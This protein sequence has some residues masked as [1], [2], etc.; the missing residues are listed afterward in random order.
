[1]SFGRWLLFHAENLKTEMERFAVSRHQTQVAQDFDAFDLHCAALDKPPDMED[2]VGTAVDTLLTE[3]ERWF[4]DAELDIKN[5]VNSHPFYVMFEPSLG[6]DART[7]HVSPKSVYPIFVADFSDVMS[8]LQCKIT[9]IIEPTIRQL[10][11]SREAL[12]FDSFTTQMAGTSGQDIEILALQRELDALKVT[13]KDL[14]LQ[15]DEIRDSLTKEINMLREQLFQKKVRIG[16]LYKPDFAPGSGMDATAV[17][18]PG[19]A[20]GGFTQADIDHAVKDVTDRFNE[21]KKRIDGKHRAELQSAETQ[22]ARLAT[23]IDALKSRLEQAEA[24]AD[25]LRTRCEEDVD[26][27]KAY[28]D[29][30]IEY[31]NSQVASL[32]EAARSASGMFE[33]E[34]AARDRDITKLSAELRDSLER[35]DY[36]KGMMNQLKREHKEELDQLRKQNVKDLDAQKADLMEKVKEAERT[37]AEMLAKN[38]DG[39]IAD[40]MAKLQEQEQRN[41]RLEKQCKEVRSEMEDAIKALQQQHDEEVDNIYAEYNSNSVISDL[42]GAVEDAE[43]EFKNTLKCVDLIFNRLFDDRNGALTKM[44]ITKDFNPA[45]YSDSKKYQKADTSHFSTEVSD[46]STLRTEPTIRVGVSGVEDLSESLHDIDK[47]M[48]DRSGRAT[49]PTNY[50]YKTVEKMINQ[51][52]MGKLANKHLNKSLKQLLAWSKAYANSK[53]VTNFGGDFGLSQLSVSTDNSMVK[54]DY[55]TKRKRHDLTGMYDAQTKITSGPHDD[56]GELRALRPLGADTEL[57]TSRIKEEDQDSRL[58]DSAGSSRKGGRTQKKGYGKSVKTTG[59]QDLTD[60]DLEPPADQRTHDGYRNAYGNYATMPDREFADQFFTDEQGIP[61]LT[62]I[63]SIVL[64][65]PQLMSERIDNSYLNK[66]KEFHHADA[67]ST[68]GGDAL[69]D[70]QPSGPGSTLHTIQAVAPYDTEKSLS[71]G[72]GRRFVDVGVNTQICT[73]ACD[74]VYFTSD[75]VPILMQ[76]SHRYECGDCLAIRNELSD[77][78]TSQGSSRHTPVSGA[79]MPGQYYSSEGGGLCGG[80]SVEWRGI[81]SSDAQEET[82]RRNSVVI[83]RPTVNSAETNDE[84][85]KLPGYDDDKNATNNEFRQRTSIDTAMKD[86]TDHE[87]AEIHF[88]VNENGERF[89]LCPRCGLRIPLSEIA[90]EM[91]INAGPPAFLFNNSPAAV[92]TKRGMEPLAPGTYLSEKELSRPPSSKEMLPT[93]SGRP[94]GSTKDVI[95]FGRPPPVDDHD[96]FTGTKYQPFPHKPFKIP[97]YPPFKPGA[98]GGAYTNPNM[99]GVFTRILQRAEE[100]RIRYLRKRELILQERK[101]TTE[102]ILRALSLL[103]DAPVVA[104]PT[105]V[106]ENMGIFAVTPPVIRPQT[107]M[108]G[109]NSVNTSGRTTRMS[110]SA[111]ATFGGDKADKN[112]NRYLFGNLSKHEDYPAGGIGLEYDTYGHASAD[113]PR[114]LSG[115]GPTSRMS[116]AKSTAS[117]KTPFEYRQCILPQKQKPIDYVA[118]GRQTIAESNQTNGEVLARLNIPGRRPSTSQT[119]SLAP[120]SRRQSIHEPNSVVRTQASKSARPNVNETA[121]KRRIQSAQVYGAGI[122]GDDNA[123]NT[124][125]SIN[126]REGSV[127]GFRGYATKGAGGSRRAHA[128]SASDQ[129]RPR[130][131]Y[132]AFP[133]NALGDRSAH[134]SGKLSKQVGVHVQRTPTTKMSDVFDVLS[135]VGMVQKQ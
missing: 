59:S 93:M 46:E 52:R 42:S 3:V 72:S 90:K 73:T 33:G 132:S 41:E 8:S 54:E 102:R 97:H 128:A 29:D 17:M 107:A 95:G 5:I 58:L 40:L 1:M 9:S 83:I 111:N 86:S 62:V 63:N 120:G 126:G 61:Q 50:L 78:H 130:S 77:P 67:A 99:E 92:P 85:G 12:I 114:R 98:R 101:R 51:Q 135:T 44:L 106:S 7:D 26:K 45:D 113:A 48:S 104:Q 79:Y 23:E 4:R 36:L 43:K 75:K 80:R 32:T 6:C 60:A 133:A 57:I 15:K 103:T 91:M 87:H 47:S 117:A 76:A 20:G 124:N 21:E 13:A 64:S 2:F 38:T 11:G 125:N 88:V 112:L 31:L 109:S 37:L 39:Q 131:A 53:L 14:S 18:L 27:Q 119:P 34:L 115:G 10:I 28:Y 100:L 35:E 65:D 129:Y 16:G 108:S 123:Q 71:S 66:S 56:L 74:N 81:R 19:S 55:G 121:S 22:T 69:S 82:D 127:D 25:A 94:S 134:G 24:E 49:I 118:K 105:L 68:R 96:G 89:I 70:V 122:M 30:Q 110:N 116:S 84:L